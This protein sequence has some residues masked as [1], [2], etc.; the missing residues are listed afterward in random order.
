MNDITKLRE[1]LFAAIEGVKAGTMG[2][3]QARAVNE[4]SKTIVDTARVEVQYL[5]V[6]GGGESAFLDTT[7]GQENLP[8]GIRSITR[9]RLAG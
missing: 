1:H 2:L 9:H 5:G 7:I 6:T 8:S 3:D 4:I